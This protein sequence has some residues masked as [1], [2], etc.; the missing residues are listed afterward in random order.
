MKLYATLYLTSTPS[1][2]ASVFGTYYVSI[3][4][5]CGYGVLVVRGRRGSHAPATGLLLQPHSC[6]QGDVTVQYLLPP[7][8]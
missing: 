3:K 1:C 2:I 7:F 6:T 8:K 4:G 5:L